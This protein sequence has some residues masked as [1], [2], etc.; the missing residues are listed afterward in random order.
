M[1][2]CGRSTGW[3]SYIYVDVDISKTSDNGNY[4]D[5]C[6]NS[7]S[8]SKVNDKPEK[9]YKR[10]THTPV[11]RSH[12]I[13]GINYNGEK[14]GSIPVTVGGYYNKNLTVYYLGYDEGNL[15]PLVVGI[16]KS[17]T[18]YEYYTKV[19]YFVTS[20]RWTK[21]KT[22]T[23][24]R[25]L[26][27]KLQ[28]ISR[29]LTTVIILKIDQ[30]TNG[31]YRAN[32]TEKPPE[33]NK[34][35]Q[36]TVEGYAYEKVYK[37]FTHAPTGRISA[38]RLLS[39][40]NAGNT[41]PFNPPVYESEYM[42]ACIYYWNGDFW[43]SNP[44]LLELKSKSG[45]LS[46]YTL[47]D[48]VD[49]KWKSE[50]GIQTDKIKDKLD[51]LNCEKNNAH[52]I[53]ISKKNKTSSY[54][55][56]TEGCNVS[57]IFANIGNYEYYS[58]T[59]HSIDSSIRRFQDKGIEQT[60][61]NSPEGATQVYVY[62]CP[63]GPEGVPL[64]IYLPGSSNSW[65]QRRSLGSTEWTDVG[66]KPSNY[67]DDTN[68]LRLIKDKLPIVII[69]VG[70]TKVHGDGEST[71]Y[72]DPSGGKDKEKI[73]LKRENKDDCFVGFVHSVL[74]K[75]VFVAG[76]VKY[77]SSP[78]QG[79]DLSFILKSVTAY[80]YDKGG[81]DFKLDDLLMI[82]FEKRGTGSKN[83]VYY[84]RNGGG[85]RWIS[86]PGKTEKLDGRD[87]TDQLNQLKTELTEAKE[88]LD[89]EKKKS[90]ESNGSVLTPGAKAGI[91]IA[92][93]GA[94]GG[95]IGVAVW[96]GPALIARLITRL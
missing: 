12:Y 87:L 34:D 35:T 85:S 7:I 32:G 92:S 8:F 45:T 15:V 62:H 38:M 64:L 73:N 31:N 88:R 83:Y 78:L 2:T 55:C 30:V 77:G 47:S 57:I 9:G 1:T 60:G 93:V 61:I 46:Y 81:P 68:I 71:Y 79:I 90:R 4:T 22:I 27:T 42:E 58:Q 91:G 56:L 23:Q 65:F 86:I 49:K 11:V 6:H 94:G 44:L 48:G 89:A 59:I 72:E 66:N 33:A 40:K 3:R 51:Q 67:K 17:G 39:T 36:I 41:I 96:K 10:Y 69:N 25:Q 63:K 95:A 84:S 18:S 75:D 14:Q 43:Y 74:N 76:Y 19:D 24:E 16:T 52:V 29:G 54:Q 37:R 26:S 5:N 80:Y 53:E 70:D 20:G 21:E 28:E 82:G 13:G 50:S